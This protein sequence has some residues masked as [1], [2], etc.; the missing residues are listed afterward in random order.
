M[1]YS[2]LNNRNEA[3]KHNLVIGKQNKCLKSY[4]KKQIYCVHTNGDLLSKPSTGGLLEI[5]LFP[6]DLC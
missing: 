4:T 5:R 3:L 6:A 1:L 2:G